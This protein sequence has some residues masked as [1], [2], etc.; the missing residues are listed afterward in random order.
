MPVAGTE[1]AV[2][3]VL[4]AAIRRAAVA[5]NVVAVVALL[6]RIEYPVTAEL[7]GFSSDG[8]IVV[9]LQHRAVMA[10]A[11]AIEGVAVVTLLVWLDLAVAAELTRL[12]THR[13]GPSVLNGAG[14][15]APVT[16]DPLAVVALLAAF[17]SPVSA[18][19]ARSPHDFAPEAFRV[20]PTSPRI[21]IPFCASSTW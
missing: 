7:T 5:R 14:L 15:A 13:T 16:P 12:P 3:N 20:D 1:R 6:V 4:D 2:W 9:F 19:V 17:D 11:V 8:S 10:A 18:L 21:S